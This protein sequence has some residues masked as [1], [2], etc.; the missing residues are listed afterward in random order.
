[1]KLK[2]A[3]SLHWLLSAGRT[4]QWI[5]NYLTVNLWGRCGLWCS[6][7]LLLLTTVHGRFYVGSVG[8]VPPD[9]LIRPTPSLPPDSKASWPFWRDFWGPKMLQNPNFPGLRASEAIHYTVLPRLLADGERTHW[10]LSR[11]PPPL[12]G[13]RASFLRVSESNLLQSWQPC[14]LAND[15]FQM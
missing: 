12:S 6:L 15:R 5:W 9:S 13:L 7:T 8:H 14:Y 4:Q 11:T 2:S 3:D 10:P 1:M